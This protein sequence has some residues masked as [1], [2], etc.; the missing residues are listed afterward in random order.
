MKPPAW[1]QRPHSPFFQL[2]MSTYLLIAFLYQ[3]LKDRLKVIG[4]IS[5]KLCASMRNLFIK[6]KTLILLGI[7][8]ALG[9]IATAHF[10]PATPVLAQSR[11]Q[12][13]VSAAASLT[14]A[15]KETA[16]LYRRSCP[17]VNLH[18]NF[19]SSGALQQQIE[20]GAPVDVF[21]SAAEKQM[22]ALQQKNLLLSGTRRNLLINRMVLIVPANSS[23]IINLQSLK[24]GNV[25][26]IAIGDPR[27]VPAGQYAEQ[28]LRKQGL[29]DSLKSKYVLATNVRQVLQFVESGN[30]QAGLVYITDAKTTS[31][32]EVV[33]MIPA[34]LNDPIVYPIAVIK[35]S[36]NT[37]TARNFSQFLSGN[38]ARKVFTRYGFGMA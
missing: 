26:R 30:A 10:R 6:F 32:V 2:M 16:L 28:I 15:L 25:K 17:N 22:N 23:G 21:I 37:A 14:D 4:Y 12:L 7:V 5:A 29:W 8:V 19:A 31:Q 33:Q 36:N 9:I 1:G 38:A 11:T 24:N 20:N 27:S 34:N 3:L 35:T 13:T 18:Y